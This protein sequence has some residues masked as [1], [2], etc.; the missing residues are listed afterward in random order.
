[1]EAAGVG[2]GGAGY[3]LLNETGGTRRFASELA[4]LTMT[5]VS[6]FMISLFADL[7]GVIVPEDIRGAPPRAVPFIET[8]F[9]ARY[10]YDSSFSYRFFVTPALDLRWGPLRLRPSAWFAADDVNARLQALAGYRL[11]GPTTTP[12]RGQGAA[13]GSFF[14]V[15][16]AAAH[17]RFGEIA[18]PRLG[19]GRGFAITTLEA[20]VNGRLD[21]FRVAK[22]LR[23]SFM[24]LGGGGA[25]E[26]HRY[27]D[28][29]FEGSTMLLLRMAYGVYIGAP[30]AP[31]G[32]AA[33]YYEHR[34]DGFAGGL[35]LRDLAD[36]IP[37]SFGASGRFFFAPRWGVGLEVQGG[38]AVIAG[39]SLLHRY[40][41]DP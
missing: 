28:L 8:E 24:E 1:M 19:G 39:A 22:P 7:Y 31:W 34:N 35:L 4:A 16:V 26:L 21:M 27:G 41:A 36:R 37:G 29:S 30:P 40:G 33:F 20:R 10:V 5:G 18:S 9:G 32:E 12:E 2:L 17:H 11:S 14:D 23:G 25:V 38:A 13:D 6:L 3:I 15:E